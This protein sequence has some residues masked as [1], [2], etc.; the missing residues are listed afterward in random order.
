M[1]KYSRE[2]VNAAR[3]TSDSS[4]MSI[5]FSFFSLQGSWCEHPSSLQEYLRSLRRHQRH[6]SSRCYQIPARRHRE[7]EMR[8]FPSI[9]RWCWQNCSSQGVQAH[10]GSLAREVRQG[11]H[12]SFGEPR[13]QCRDQ[14]TRCRQAR[15]DSRSVQRGPARQ[16]SNL[17][18]SRSNQRLHEYPMPR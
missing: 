3:G 4:A 16:T 9:Q 11:D 15:P 13:F 8:P 7:E 12:W 1:V 2:P 17:Q 6:Q 5:H 18:S 10:S 14:V